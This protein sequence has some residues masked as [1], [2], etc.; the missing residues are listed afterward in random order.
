[1]E[2]ELLALLLL[3]LLVLQRLV[4]LR[5]GGG[6][7]LQWVRRGGKVHSCKACVFFVLLECLQ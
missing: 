6:R 3:M 7:S 4:V 2:A 1:M 5:V